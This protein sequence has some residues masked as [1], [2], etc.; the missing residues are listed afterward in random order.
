[1]DKSKD[2]KPTAQ[3]GIT[4]AAQTLR[5]RRQEKRDLQES[6]KKQEQTEEELE[7]SQIP[8]P[9]TT[10]PA[11][12]ISE[13]WREQQRLL[14]A[15]H[16]QVGTKFST[17]SAHNVSLPSI[18]SNYS[19]TLSTIYDSLQSPGLRSDTDNYTPPSLVM[20][21]VEQELA[22]LNLGT[23]SPAPAATSQTDEHEN[24][25]KIDEE[26]LPIDASARRQ[27]LEQMKLKLQ[28]RRERK[29]RDEED[30]DEDEDEEEEEEEDSLTFAAFDRKLRVQAAAW[31]IQRLEKRSSDSAADQNTELDNTELRFGP[32]NAGMQAVM[33]ERARRKREAAATKAALEEAEM[34]D[35][36][37]NTS[38]AL[39]IQNPDP[40][41][42]MQD[43]ME[44]RARRRRAKAAADEALTSEVG[45]SPSDAAPSK[46]ET[47]AKSQ[48]GGKN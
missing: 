30:E 19:T 43:V 8:E 24:E 20:E 10:P 44:E 42:G 18:T 32:P 34:E 38:T 28:R 40:I 26:C 21:W 25:I 45:W 23:Y 31:E 22:E 47:P 15:K 11:K 41:R 36:T 9:S 12:T 13:Q 17:T 1:M 39:S 16:Q 27:A 33:G 6:K 2:A 14:E 37:F 5:Q 3:S 7:R 35:K 46:L 29:E 48:R 4:Q